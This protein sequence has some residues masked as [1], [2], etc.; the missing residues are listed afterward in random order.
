MLWICSPGAVNL[1]GM[2]SLRHAVADDAPFLREMLAAAADWRKGSAVRSGD[3]VMRDPHVG[4]YLAGW[5]RDGDFGVIAE[6]AGVSVGAAW[7]RFFDSEP[8]GYGFVAPD[9][10]ELKI[11]VV[12]E[13]RRRGIG[14][15]LL[16]EV[17][18]QAQ[19]RSID[20]ISLSVEADNPAI[21]MYTDLGFIEEFRIAHSPTMVIDCRAK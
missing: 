5:P 16:A 10:P 21:D 2:T 17:V 20:R 18:L 4:H 8:R 1:R 6:D 14:R 3:E 7:C 13:R 11:G 19:R 12:T 15:L 9:V